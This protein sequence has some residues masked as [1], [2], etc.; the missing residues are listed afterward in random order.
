MPAAQT[1]RFEQPNSPQLAVSTARGSCCS[2]LTLAAHLAAAAARAA[3]SLFKLQEEAL[4][5]LPL[6]RGKLHFESG[7]INS[8][9]QPFIL[10]AA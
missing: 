1:S 4:K 6:I 5:G 2:R 3:S 8:P 9:Q 10:W 7:W